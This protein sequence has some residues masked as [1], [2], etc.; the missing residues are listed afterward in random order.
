MS[1]AQVSV[2]GGA[3]EYDGKSFR[4]EFN[5]RMNAD[6]RHLSYWQATAERYSIKISSPSERP[7]AVP[8]NT[9]RLVEDKYCQGAGWLPGASMTVMTQQEVPQARKRCFRSPG[10]AG[11]L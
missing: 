7:L 1:V 2:T 5:R 10:L 3:P 9:M 8:S 6:R 11:K 4:E